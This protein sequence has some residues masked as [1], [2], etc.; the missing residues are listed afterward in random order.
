MS[1]AA[2]ADGNAA[3]SLAANTSNSCATCASDN[4]GGTTRTNNRNEE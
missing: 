3:T 1:H 4:S 2:P